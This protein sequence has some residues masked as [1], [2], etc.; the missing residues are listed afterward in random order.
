[1]THLPLDHAGPR[2]TREARKVAVASFVG[3]AIEWYDFFL[4][5]AAAALVFGPQFFPSGDPVLSQLGSFATFAVGF[6]TRPLG[7]MIAGHFGDRIGR[8]RILILSLLLMGSAT[9]V[10]GLLPTYAQI[11]VAAPVI[12]V[13]L[14]LL[15]GLAV[16]A[17]WG[18]AA[19]MA[20]EHAPPKRRTLYGSSTQLG[21]PA[22]AILANLMMLVLSATTGPAFTAWG[23]RI[24]F[25]ASIVLVVFGLVVRRTLTESPLFAQ[26]AA[27]RATARVP[28]VQVLRRYPA[29]VLVAIFATAASPAIGYTVLT[30]ILSYGTEHVGYSRDALLVVII[31]ISALQ[32]VSTL[33]LADAADRWGRRRTMVVGS[34]VQVVAALAFFPL[35]DTGVVLLAVVACGFA[36]V[37]NTAQY[38]PLPAVMSD[39]FPTNLRY[40]GSSL[41]YQFGSIVGG[42]L[43]PIVAT[44]LYAG[45]RNSLLIGGYLAG[46]TVLALVAILLAHTAALTHRVTDAERRLVAK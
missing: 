28:L 3:T 22:G 39:L 35:F 14:R 21:V 6:L 46:M 10:V 33:V 9:V 12:L 1:M 34:L 25:V 8:K 13:V 19:L 11:G 32:F 44:A 23:W 16:G 15:Q 24:G 29:G 5:G 38:A 40:S 43:A 42:S 4:Y 17:E 27:R 18:G 2:N 37:A 7:G 41:G 45:T 36:M 30:F 20:V 31:V 26:A